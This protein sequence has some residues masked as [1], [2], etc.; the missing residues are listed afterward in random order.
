VKTLSKHIKS[1]KNKSTSVYDILGKN[2]DLLDICEKKKEQKASKLK[3]I[4]AFLN[5]KFEEKEI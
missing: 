2:I 3:Q 5:S 1:L 4:Y